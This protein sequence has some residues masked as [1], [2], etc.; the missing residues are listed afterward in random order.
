M[1]RILVADDDAQQLELRAR[2]LEAGGHEVAAAFSPSEALRQLAAAEVVIM[3]LRFPNAKGRP[4]AAEGLRLIRQVRDSGCRAPIL[5]VSGWPE[6]LDGAEEAQFVTRVLVKPVGMAALL[7][8]IR[9]CLTEASAP[10]RNPLSA[11][12]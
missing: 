8:A 5:V 1:A 3:D 2:L 10:G 9:D 12:P 4:E 11:S 6:D 7:A